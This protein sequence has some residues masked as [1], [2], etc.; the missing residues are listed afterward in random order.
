MPVGRIRDKVLY[1]IG[2]HRGRMHRYTKVRWIVAI[3]STVAVALLPV[4]GIC[5]FDFW[6]GNHVILGEVVPLPVAAKS[7]AYP[8]LAVNILIVI[9]SRTVGRYLCGF[10]CPYGALTRLREWLRYHSKEPGKRI[11]T[12]FLMLF[13][14]L[15]LSAIVFTFW[16]DWR[17]FLEGS[18]LAKAI[19]TTFLLGM[20]GG[21]FGLVRFLGIG[22]C[23]SWCPSGVYFAILGPDSFNGVE[24]AHEEN[25]TDCGACEKACPVDLQPRDMSGGK[26]REGLGFYVDGMSN[27]ANCLRCG[28]CVNACE[29]MTDRYEKETPLR[30]GWLPENARD[31]SEP[32]QVAA[33][34]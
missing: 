10:A 17:V 22:F 20:V 6:G 31:S 7:F 28:D 34:E 27:F 21:L 24:F 1:G 25:C 3:L 23:R 4:L 16:V 9:A 14:S 32:T 5:R 18:T 11:L 12:E 33:S 2:K 26:H 13:A 19:S 30:L 29:G 15:L 8:F